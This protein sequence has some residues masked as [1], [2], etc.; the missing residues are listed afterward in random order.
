MPHL[1]RWKGGPPATSIMVEGHPPVPPPSV[2]ALV[3]AQ[4]R[5]RPG[6]CRSRAYR[7]R[8]GDWSTAVPRPSPRRSSTYPYVESLPSKTQVHPFQA[9]RPSVAPR[10]LRSTRV[11]EIL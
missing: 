5:D 4:L 9:E 11:G 6:K 2:T 8:E 7:S 10:E 1:F 3:R